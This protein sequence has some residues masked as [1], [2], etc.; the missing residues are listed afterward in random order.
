[1]EIQKKRDIIAG[2]KKEAKE[3]EQLF[4]HPMI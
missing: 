4:Q 1:M 3:L 2:N